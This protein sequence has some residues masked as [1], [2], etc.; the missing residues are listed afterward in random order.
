MHKKWRPK[1]FLFQLKLLS[2]F[3]RNP[4]IYLRWCMSQTKKI[5]LA[6]L[7]LEKSVNIGDI[8]ELEIA[9]I[10]IISFKLV[11]IT[12]FPWEKKWFKKFQL[13]S[14]TVFFTRKTTISQKWYT[15]PQF[16]EYQNVMS[17]RGCSVQPQIFIWSVSSSF[18]FDPN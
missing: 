7:I 6:I 16:L 8:E 11:I 1:K 12:F 18:Y 9:N 14:F 13:D 3:L 15:L 17:T 5:H 4:H 10:I 2:L